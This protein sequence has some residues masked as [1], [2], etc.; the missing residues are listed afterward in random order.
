[1][2]TKPFWMTYEDFYKA[3]FER[4]LYLCR[5]VI[6]NEDDAY[7]LASDV[8]L[9]IS[10]R[11]DS[12]MNP[13]HYLNRT[14]SRAI[15]HK[16]KSLQN[17]RNNSTD[18]TE[19]I[20]DPSYLE[21]EFSD[22][23]QVLLRKKREL[24]IRAVNQVLNE[25]DETTRFIFRAKTLGRIDDKALMLEMGI[26]RNEFKNIVESTQEKIKRVLS[27]YGESGKRL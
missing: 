10:M 1:M 14:L 24:V 16:K 27:T 6:R 7:D 3:N 11:Y 19:D 25:S 5:N 20:P 23:E 17:I 4:A 2:G 15:L 26:T 13:V 12:I 8:F 22:E 21:G 9:A 18:L